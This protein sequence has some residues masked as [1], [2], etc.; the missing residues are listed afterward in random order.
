M[1]LTTK[2]PSAAALAFGAEANLDTMKTQISQNQAAIQ[3]LESLQPL[4]PGQFQMTLSPSAREL[5]V[6][7]AAAAAAAAATAAAGAAPAAGAGSGLLQRGSLLQNPTFQNQSVDERVRKRKR[8]LAELSSPT[9]NIQT[10]PFTTAAVSSIRLLDSIQTSQQE[11][12]QLI[13]AQ[14]ER[15]AQLQQQTEVIN[16]LQQQIRDLNNQKGVQTSVI[17]NL[18]AQL[19][20]MQT[21]NKQ[22]QE[23][24]QRYAKNINDNILAIDRKTFPGTLTA[25]LTYALITE[26]NAD[27]AYNRDEFCLVTLEAIQQKYQQLL[28]SSNIK[29]AANLLMSISGSLSLLVFQLMQRNVQG[30][31]FEDQ[32]RFQ[33]ITAS[34]PSP[35]ILVNQITTILDRGTTG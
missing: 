26:M 8:A 4:Q 14:N 33:Q 3:S 35:E 17:Q 5:A 34:I 22:F 19:F 7:P 6:A 15:A 23:S 11:K 25:Q 24:V 30:T 13:D 2:P 29:A 27:C 32:F 10:N 16:T 9:G 1:A 21:E 18:Q 12:K 28:A 31:I 20:T